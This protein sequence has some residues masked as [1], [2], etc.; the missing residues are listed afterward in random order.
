MGVLITI[1]RGTDASRVHNPSK[2][3]TPQMIS[4][5]PTKCAV[6]AGWPKPMRVKRSTPILG[7]V[8]FRIPCVKKIS[9]TGR[10]IR[11]RLAGPPDGLRKKRRVEFMAWPPE[12]IEDEVEGRSQEPLAKGLLVAALCEWD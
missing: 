2:T 3:S 5:V 4:N 9:P 12:V 7:S 10:R 8:N 6:K 11:N 1:S